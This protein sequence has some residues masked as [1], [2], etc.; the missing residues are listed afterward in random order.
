MT[1]IRGADVVVVGAGVT[2]TSIAYNL[3]KLG[4]D[5]LVVERD[6]LAAGSSGACDGYVVLQTKSPGI[7]LRLAMESV[8]LCRGLS[9]ELGYDV[10]YSRAGALIVIRTPAEWKVM[11][12]RARTQR[13]AGLNIELLDRRQVMEREPFL[14]GRFEGAAF[15]PQDGQI[16]PLSL[17]LGFARAARRAGVRFLLQ[18]PVTRVVLDSRGVAGIDTSRGYLPCRTLVVACGVWTPLLL[19]PLGLDVPIKPRRGQLM[20]TERL[21]RTL[22]HGILDARY[23][24]IKF[25]PELA[26][27]ED[28]RFTRLGVALGLEQT[29]HGN[30]LVGNTREFVGYDNRTTAEGIEAMKE[31]AVSIAPRLKDIRIIRTFAGLRPYTPDGLPL[32][33]PVPEIP[34]LVLA[35]GHEGDGIILAA[36]TGRLVAASIIERQVPS[37]MEACLPGRFA[38]S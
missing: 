19:K 17:N 16:D 18:T 38:L 7:H 33:G 23:I 6:D 5:V 32:L 26:G 10:H 27:A 3:A 4:A 35:A 24:A 2:G 36:I 25:D 31:Y 34:G 30:I 9:E 29:H 14:T 37:L 22:N 12:E 15:S 28:N 11:E 20:V 21:P 13:A 8:D 1:Q